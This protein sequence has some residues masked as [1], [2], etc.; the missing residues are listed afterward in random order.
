MRHTEVA[1]LIVPDDLTY[2][3]LDQGDGDPPYDGWGAWVEFIA[4]TD[5]ITT[6]KGISF[7]S[8]AGAILPEIQIG[9]GAEGLEEECGTFAVAVRNGANGG[10]QRYD[11]PAPVS[12][13]PAHSRVCL[14]QRQDSGTELNVALRYAYSFDSEYCLDYNQSPMGV[15]PLQSTGVVLT[16]NAEEWGYS[17]W[18]VLTEGHSDPIALAAIVLAGFPNLTFIHDW[19]IGIGADGL[20]QVVWT[21]PGFNKLGVGGREP[22]IDPL[23]TGMRYIPA[24]TRI[25][26]RVRK[27]GTDVTPW[28]VKVNYYGPVSLIIDE[29][30]EPTPTSIVVRK[31]I[32]SGTDRD[33]T[34]N[35]GGGLTPDAFTLSD[36]EQHEFTGLAPGTYSIEEI[37]PD[38]WSSESEVSNDD[39]P[40]AI[41]VA[42]GDTVIVTFYNTQDSA[43]GGVEEPDFDGD[44]IPFTN[45]IVNIGLNH[46]GINKPLTDEELEAGTASPAAV[47]AALHV[48]PAVNETLRDFPWPFATKYATLT[49]LRG[50]AAS[51]VN[52]DW[53]FEYARPS[54]CVYERR[55]VVARGTAVNPTPPPF[56]LSRNSD[57]DAV[58]WTN[59][60]NAELEYTARGIC[61]A[62][63]GDILFQEALAWRFAFKFAPS[64]SRIPDRAKYCEEMYRAVLAKAYDVIK[65]GNAGPRPE[66]DED[67]FDQSGDAQAANLAVVNNALLAINAR[68]ITALDGTDQSRE[69]QAVRTVFGQ[70]LRTVLE[71]HDWR[72]ATRYRIYDPE[73]A[74]DLIEG[75]YPATG[76]I[77]DQ[78]NYNWLFG[79]RV[80]SACVRARGIVTPG[81]GRTFNATPEAFELGSDSE[82]RLLYVNCDDPVLEYT[83]RI[84]EVVR[85]GGALF[86][87]ALGW[88][89]AAHLALTLAQVNPVEIEQHGR[90]A[91][92]TD[93][94][95]KTANVTSSQQQARQRVADWAHRKY[96]VAIGRAQVQDRRQTSP[97]QPSDGLPDWIRLR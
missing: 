54:D 38:G 67:A 20:E 18:A 31:V 11:F 5:F 64:L 7:R 77:A 47:V 3:A 45:A 94:S 9:L 28:N 71:A 37:V 63:E 58:I 42:E 87:E 4:D 70:Q 15:F 60:P 91:D 48:R 75:T 83:E 81:V 33:F 10:M 61:P 57:G 86:N 30:P 40:D 26:I 24:D 23:A 78:A 8:T 66:V 93:Q 95:R 17:D 50:S 96:E 80:P 36:G 13:I 49:R 41:T 29:E 43:G 12:G 1:D 69:A 16:P 56:Q 92:A 68:T 97:Q 76:D 89:L 65:P 73:D 46:V 6:L 90:G 88:K 35:A 44:C 39:A 52:G 25:V 55:I 14:R 53:A 85:W 19:E 32:L 59:E 62:F 2:I 72:F 27:S 82:G 22:A 34:F 51:P 84:D 21:H 74:E 79:F